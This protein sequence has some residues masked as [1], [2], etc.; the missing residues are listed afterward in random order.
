[1]SRVINRETAGKERKTLMRSVALALREL[2]RQSE[3]D[4]MSRDLA[5]YLG[6]TLLEI[7]ETVNVS[8]AAWEKRDYW[9]KA[10]RYRME[11]IWSE[12]LGNQMCAAVSKDDW[13]QIAMISAQIAQ[14]VM[15]IEVPKRHRLGTPWEGAWKRF[16]SER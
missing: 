8:V 6:M 10:D 15:S 3:P 4:Q 5:A 13:G 16:Q 14:Q 2:M 11:W 12:Q 9:V 1:M 7:F